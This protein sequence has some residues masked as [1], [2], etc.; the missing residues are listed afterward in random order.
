MADRTYRFIRLDVF[1]TTPLEGNQLAVFPDARGLS[2]AEMQALA[3]EMN[4]SETTFVLPRDLVTERQKGIR[5]RI[6]TVAEELPFAGHPTLGTA[7]ALHGTDRRAEAAHGTFRV[8]SHDN[9][10]HLDLNAGKVPVEFSFRDGRLFGEMTQPDPQFGHVLKAEDVAPLA[11]LE[12]G[13]I[14]SRLPVQTVSTGMAFAIVPL[15]SAEA[16]GRIALDW[17]RAEAYLA[18]TD[19]KFLYFLAPAADDGGAPRM[20][21]R[22]I[23]YSGEDPGT[24]SAAGCAAAWM[25]RHG[26]ARPEQTVL[27]EQGVEMHRR[28]VIHVRA[29][30]STEG[31]SVV[32]VRVGGN[33]VEV[34]QGE[35]FL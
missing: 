10:I 24:G 28:C 27:I 26:V 11:G 23:F 7:A 3:R 29:S 14:E 31:D 19:A 2:D 33:V 13:D 35:V 4:L 18:R 17:R 1:T 8:H 21:A 32:N 12:A 15:K 16:L 34:M 20:R 9:I 22:M 6:F 5:V 30:K 25:V